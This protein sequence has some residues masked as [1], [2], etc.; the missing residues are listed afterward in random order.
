MWGRFY[1][2]IL[3]AG[4]AVRLAGEGAKVGFP[5]IHNLLVLRGWLAPAG[6][7]RHQGRWARRPAPPGFS[8]FKGL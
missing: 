7:L 8:G 6:N 3:R 4:K 2:K 1:G 5:P